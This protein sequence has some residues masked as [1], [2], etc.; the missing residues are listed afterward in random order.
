MSFTVVDGKVVALDVL[1]DP[2]RSARLDLTGPNQGDDVFPAFPP[3]AR[4]RGRSILLDTRTGAVNLDHG[5]DLGSRG[6]PS[7]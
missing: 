1:S 4:G 7:T 3:S 2:D 6:R 5:D